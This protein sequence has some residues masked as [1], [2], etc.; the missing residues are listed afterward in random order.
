MISEISSA[1]DRTFSH[2]GWVF[3]LLPLKQLRKSKFWKNEKK[4]ARRYHFTY[5]CHK[6]QSYGVWFLRYGALRTEFF[7]ILDHFMLFYSF[8][9]LTTQKIKI[10]YKIKSNPWRY[11]HF[12]KVYQNSWSYATLFLRYGAWRI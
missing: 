8:T 9:P 3:A 6:W 11:H 10:F 7:I 12:T 5:V 1:A 4:K 2:F